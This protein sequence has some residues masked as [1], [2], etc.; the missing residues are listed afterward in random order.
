METREDMSAVGN[1]S[2]QVLNALNKTSFGQIFA[3]RA[4]VPCGKDDARWVKAF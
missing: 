4:R 2:Q 3:S 1:Y